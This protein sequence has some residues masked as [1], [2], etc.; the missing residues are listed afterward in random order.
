MKLFTYANVFIYFFLETNNRNKKLPFS[1]NKA[2][3]GFSVPR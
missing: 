2:L 1:K 3:K